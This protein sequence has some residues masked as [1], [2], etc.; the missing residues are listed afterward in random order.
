M[1]YK[2]TQLY[3]RID[4]QDLARRVGFY[5]LRCADA[6]LPEEVDHVPT[7]SLHLDVSPEDADAAAGAYRPRCCGAF[8]ICSLLCCLLCS[9]LLLCF[10]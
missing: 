1:Y 8:L 3:C 6:Q 10:I 4:C 7:T 2:Q 9:S 5:M